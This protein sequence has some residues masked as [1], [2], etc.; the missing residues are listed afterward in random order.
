MSLRLLCIITLVLTACRHDSWTL[1]NPAKDRVEPVEFRVP[2]CS[3]FLGELDAMSAKELKVE[4]DKVQKLLLDKKS[5]E[6]LRASLI[7]GVYQAKNKNYGKAVEF[8]SPLSNRKSLDDPCRL[9]VRIYS[10][11]LEDLSQMEKDLNSEKK[12]KAE[13]ERKL[14]ALSD[15]EKEIS[16]RDTKIHGQ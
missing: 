10:D 1:E 2:T 7:A 16:Q 8:L 12:Q 6:Y 14:K 5:E 11:L 9:S 15:I 3:S 13:L 4:Y